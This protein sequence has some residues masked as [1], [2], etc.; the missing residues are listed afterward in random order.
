M[1]KAFRFHATGGPEVLRF[2]DVAAGAPGPGEVLLR[3]EAVAVNYRDILLRRGRSLG[4]ACAGQGAVNQPDD[5]EPEQQGRVA[6][7]GA[8]ALGVDPAHSLTPD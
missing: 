3:N 7:D 5:D 8:P 6:G 1:P 2:E 4:A